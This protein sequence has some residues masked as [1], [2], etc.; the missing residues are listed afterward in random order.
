MRIIKIVIMKKLT[1]KQ[2]CARIAMYDEAI[3][4]LHCYESADDEERVHEEVQKLV[5]IRQI[6]ALKNRFVASL[7]A[8]SIPA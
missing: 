5:V 7:N 8:P 4:A 3:S 1:E 6:E 2:I